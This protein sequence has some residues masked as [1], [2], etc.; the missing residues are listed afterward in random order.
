VPVARVHGEV[1][2]E[3]VQE[4]GSTLA[5]TVGPRDRGLVLDLSAV[6]YSTAPACTSCTSSC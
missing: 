1:D 3:R 6:D 5:E 2:L 4:L